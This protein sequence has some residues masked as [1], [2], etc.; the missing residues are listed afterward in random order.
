MVDWCF[1]KAAARA[2]GYRVD[3]Y[4]LR[5]DLRSDFLL[6]WPPFA[7]NTA[8]SRCLAESRV[9]IYLH[10]DDKWLL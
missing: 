9:R 6:R 7:C 5:E 1:A 2:K 3:A 10:E 4:A 8:A